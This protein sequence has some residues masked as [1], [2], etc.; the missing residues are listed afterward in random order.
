MI[1]SDV[2]GLSEIIEPGN[3]G[4]L[5]PADDPTALARAITMAASDPERLRT[6]GE[7]ARERARL[8]SIDR[9]VEQ[10]EAF[11]RRLLAPSQSDAP[12]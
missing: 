6:E 10:T 12:R 5:V 8:F 3:G 1:A 4:W 7:R 11:Y 9:M 2:G